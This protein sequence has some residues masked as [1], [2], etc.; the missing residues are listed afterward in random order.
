MPIAVHTWHCLSVVDL[1][2]AKEG[3]DPGAGLGAVMRCTHL[4]P[5]APHHSSEGQSAGKPLDFTAFCSSKTRRTRVQRSHLAPN[6][7]DY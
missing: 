3:N 4:H 5:H 7:P 2:G 1:G 6:S